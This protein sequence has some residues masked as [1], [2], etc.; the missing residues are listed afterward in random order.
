MNSQLPELENIKST[1]LDGGYYKLR[2]RENLTVLALN[3]LPFNVMNKPQLQGDQITKQF[4]WIVEELEK[5]DPSEKFILSYHI[6]P[7]SMIG[8]TVW[9]QLYANFTA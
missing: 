3:T 4:D 2:L 9:S 7:G 1:F 6:Y 5:A 8:Q